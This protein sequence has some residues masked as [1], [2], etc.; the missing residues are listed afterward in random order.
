[1]PASAIRHP[2]VSSPTPV[3]T[4]HDAIYERR[5]C[6]VVLPIVGTWRLA[7]R[8]PAR[9]TR[10]RVPPSARYADA[11]AGAPRVAPSAAAELDGASRSLRR[12]GSWRP[13]FLDE[14]RDLARRATPDELSD[15]ARSAEA[16]IF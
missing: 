10:S 16:Q 14:N 6:S 5:R 9:G 2:I 8:A 4:A 7:L 1:M 11:P 13:S 12:A 3:V 15:G